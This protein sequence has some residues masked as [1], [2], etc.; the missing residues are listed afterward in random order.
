MVFRHSWYEIKVNRRVQHTFLHTIMYMWLSS[1]HKM[2]S[3]YS[4]SRCGIYHAHLHAL[5]QFRIYGLLICRLLTIKMDSIYSCSR[6]GMGLPPDPHTNP[7]T[8]GGVL[9][10]I[11]SKSVQFD[12]ACRSNSRTEILLWVEFVLL[13]RNINVKRRGVTRITKDFGKILV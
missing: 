8:P 3:I 12:V 1:A 7:P 10:Y 2:V 13:R 5:H 9:P 4:C 6:C 11:L